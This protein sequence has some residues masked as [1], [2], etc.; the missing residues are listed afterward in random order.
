M[1]LRY[2]LYRGS[3][4]AELAYGAPSLIDSQATLDFVDAT[5]VDYTTYYYR[6]DVI[7][8]DGIPKA[9]ILDSRLYSK[10]GISRPWLV[11]SELA[12][13]EGA[14]KIGEMVEI[15]NLSSVTQDLTGYRL[16]NGAEEE[17]LTGSVPGNGFFVHTL[18]IIELSG[19]GGTLSLL[20]PDSDFVFDSVGWGTEGGAPAVPQGFSISRVSGTTA[21][22]PDATSFDISS[23]SF[24][25]ENTVE[26]P[27]LGSSIV[28]NEVYF[29]GTGGEDYVEIIN[30]SGST[31]V[32]SGFAI[33]D[34]V[35]F[36]DTIETGVQLPPGQLFVLDTNSAQGFDR[37]LVQSTLYL[38]Q[39]TEL[40]TLQ[41][42]DQLGWGSAL[43]D[44]APPAPVAPNDAVVRA[45]DGVPAYLGDQGA[46]WIES[47]GD[48]SLF[49]GPPSP[50]ER[51]VAQS[52]VTYR[53]DPLG[54]GDYLSIGQALAAATPGVKILIEPGNY[55]EALVLSDGV[56]LT[57][58]GDSENPV[59]ITGD[60]LGPA[61]S[62][63]GLGSQTRV[64]NLRIESTSGGMQLVDS[65]PT[66]S[67]LWFVGNHSSG[68]GGALSI[69]GGAPSVSGCVFQDNTSDGNG[70]AVGVV[71][72]APLF[73]Y[74]LFVHNTSLGKGGAIYTGGGTIE[75]H[76]CSLDQN[77][78]YESQGGSIHN[79]GA[80][81]SVSTSTL[82]NGV[83]G[84]SLRNEGGGSLGFSCG[85]IF[86]HPEPIPLTDTG[87]VL[88]NVLEEDP[89]FC[90]ASAMN[91]AY[92]SASPLSSL[93]AGC[94]S[95]IGTAGPPCNPTTPTGAEL[96]PRQ[97]LS[98][99]LPAMPNPFNPSTSLRF[100][101][102][103]AGRT[104]IELYDVRG[105]HIA[106]PLA[107]KQYGP[108]IHQVTWQGRD[109]NG[110]VVA[111]GV[112]F[113]VLRLNDQRMGSAQRL[114]LLK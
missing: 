95:I 46:N 6:V 37:D 27:A 90:Q 87:I 94:G 4:L 114:V 23:P 14:S 78:S 65:S 93:Q 10:P 16:S 85:L 35:A 68:D 92:S 21:E 61:I 101:L 72:G 58:N 26:A 29:E 17:T 53:V 31:I 48:L 97:N 107:E 11:L 44:F 109:S 75:M 86:N 54:G 111:S 83:A 38:Y 96:P 36:V 69:D 57:G 88:D 18:S 1:V 112:Y 24:G 91:Y 81:L 5:T 73:S 77:G 33:S 100:E 22:N 43:P 25:S 15:E 67:S 71:S 82:T 32:L 28:V 47:G 34:G 84:A 45:P 39:I 56:D 62:G 108:G 52:V 20:A 59:L 103:H 2:D 42:I 41:R 55:A 113:A 70:G 60:G 98:R 80:A 40:G 63:S 13:S 66:L 7:A 105:R 74:C 102:A 79:L 49:Y 64:S 76:N 8:D 106:T 30:P 9:E 51:N 104:Q 110:L 12:P 99:L 19:V 50:G 89:L 3:S